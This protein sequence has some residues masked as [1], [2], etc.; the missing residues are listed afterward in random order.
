MFSKKCKAH[1]DAT[2]MSRKEH[3]KH[4]FGILV[5]LK[6]AEVA[7][8]IHMVAP[9]FYETYASDKIKELAERLK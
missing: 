4:A 6:R 1:L 8:A 5:E 9:R 7:L 3:F 2:D